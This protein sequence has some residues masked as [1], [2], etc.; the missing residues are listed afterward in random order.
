MMADVPD[1]LEG[2]VSTQERLEAQDMVE[3]GLADG[4]GEAISR[5]QT[6]DDY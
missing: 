5:I 6:S 1:W 2:S 4:Y 3:T